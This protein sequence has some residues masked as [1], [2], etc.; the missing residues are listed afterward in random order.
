[1]GD[2]DN[3][4]KEE[5][6]AIQKAE[7]KEGTRKSLSLAM[8]CGTM[9][10]VLAR[11]DSDEVR[12]VRNA[13]VKV[14]NEEVHETDLTEISYV[15]SD[16]GDTY[17]VGED[18]F[19]FANLFNR[20]VCRPMQKGLISPKEVNAVDV[21]ALIIKDMIGPIDAPDSFIGYSIPAEAIDEGRSVI[22]HERVFGKIFSAI[23]LNNKPINEAMA[24]IYS[25]CQNEKFSGIA[26][27][28]GAGMTN[29]A[30]SYRGIECCK[31]ST[32]RSGDYIDKMV[33]D[34]LDMVPNRVTSIKERVLDLTRTSYPEENKRTQRILEALHYYYEN[35]I[36]YNIKRMV[37]EFDK[38][39]DVEIDEAIPIV[40]S[41]GTSMPNGFIELFSTVFN[42]Y[43]FPIKIS[44]IRRAR[45][46]LTAVAS[47]LLV[48][49]IADT[50][51]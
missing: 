35:A 8:D 28:C 5:R 44:E 36:N 10:I 24:I 2:S 40:V 32:S 49:V 7:A 12:S 25:E 27:S 29:I 15:K 37:A 39:V 14:D 11:S 41:G 20:E 30:L 43:D 33:A 38:N 18:A 6:K 47:G 16:E 51:K 13:F 4:T 45:N 17:I 34:S 26:V 3:M 50:T 19:K 42:R 9:F 31:F 46:P 22:Y 1:M 21:L 48:K 23:G